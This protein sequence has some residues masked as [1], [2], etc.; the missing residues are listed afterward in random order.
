MGRDVRKYVTACEGQYLLFTKHGIDIDK[1]PA[2]KKHLTQFMDQLTPR[3]KNWKGS[4]EWKGR[5]PG[6]YQ[7]YEIQDTID[8]YSEFE[9]PKIIIPAI[10][11]KATY[12]LD[13]SGFFSNDKTTIIGS[14]SLYLL[15]VLNSKTVDFVMHSISSTKQGGYFEYKPMYLSQL[16]IR[17]IDFSKPSDKSQHDKM[18][19]LITS[20]LDLHRQL[21]LAKTDQERTVLSRQIEATD[22]QIDRLVYDLYGLTEEEIKIV[23]GKD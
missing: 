18:V 4:S 22:R 9:K 13:T 17:T 6:S 1:Y 23:E 2:I 16:P 10:I 12:C 20:I 3:P 19:S 15:G 21:P 5:K 11:Q 7:W 8:Y 14:D